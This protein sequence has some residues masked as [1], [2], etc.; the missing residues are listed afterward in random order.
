MKQG[1][2]EEENPDPRPQV[3]KERPKH[4]A[5]TNRQQNTLMNTKP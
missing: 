3:A 1:A 2:K 5:L 4:K